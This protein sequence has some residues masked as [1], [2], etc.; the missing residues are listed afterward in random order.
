VL[1]ASLIPQIPRR[2]DARAVLGQRVLES[3]LRSLLRGHPALAGRQ[4]HRARM[5]RQL[6]YSHSTATLSLS[7][8]SVE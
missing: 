7:R 1:S 4:E 6:D 3:R 2:R 5:I 8:P